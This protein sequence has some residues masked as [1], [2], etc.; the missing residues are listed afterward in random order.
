MKIEPI[1]LMKEIA[2][3]VA[4]I[5]QHIVTLIKRQKN[6]AHYPKVINQL[7]EFKKSYP[8]V[9]QYTSPH[10]SDEST[11]VNGKQHNYRYFNCSETA[12]KLILF[13]PGGN[14]CYD[15][16]WS[17]DRLMDALLNKETN[18][19][20]KE[21]ILAPENIYPSAHED[22]L[23]WTRHLIKD[24][25]KYV[26]GDELILVGAGSGCHTALWIYNQLK[27]R[28]MIKKMV[29]VDGLYQMNTL[30]LSDLP[31][32]ESMSGTLGCYF[33]DQVHNNP[34][35]N[36]LQNSI[37]I[38]IP[39]LFVTGSGHKLANETI[40]MAAICGFNSMTVDLMVVPG[41]IHEFL[42]YDDIQTQE[43][44]QLISDWIHFAR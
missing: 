35:I 34:E 39:I 38:E 8:I 33:V 4:Q 13:F 27:D 14:F 25:N 31:S 16:R 42:M 2:P 40:Q 29:M 1:K 7:R 17:Y 44:D 11:L 9:K 10:V 23:E 41:A 26:P 15:Q 21:P 37:A 18:I 19:M 43:A 5:K 30:A 28:S 36:L 20:I 24:R 12:N 22:A 32:A 6:L 3:G